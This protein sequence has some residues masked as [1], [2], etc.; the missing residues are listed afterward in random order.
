ML[1]DS[2]NYVRSFKCAL[3]DLQNTNFQL[4][5][6]A[7]KRPPNEHARRFNAPE[8]NKVAMILAGDQ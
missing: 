5:I 6:N 8:I 3:E 7:D 2:N 4:V 1:H